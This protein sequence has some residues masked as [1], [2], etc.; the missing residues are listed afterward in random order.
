METTNSST[1]SLLSEPMINQGFLS[2]I[3]KLQECIDSLKIDQICLASDILNL[4]YE[5]YC[6][7]CLYIGTPKYNYPN[8]LKER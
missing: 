5:I 6:L 1:I 4:E 2:Q 8:L 7:K 3:K